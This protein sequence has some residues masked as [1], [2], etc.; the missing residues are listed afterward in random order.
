MVEEVYRLPENKQIRFHFT[1]D[2]SFDIFTLLKSG[3]WIWHFV[4]TGM[5]GL[6]P[7]P[8]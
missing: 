2:T 8:L 4:R 7:S 5:N 3:S 6:I 1:E